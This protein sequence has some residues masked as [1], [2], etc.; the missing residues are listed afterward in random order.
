MAVSAPIQTEWLE[1][2]SDGATVKAYFARPEGTGP[3][4]GVIMIHENPGLTPHRQDVTRRLASEGYV[5]LTPNLYSRIGGEIPR[6]DDE[7]EWKRQI[8]RASVDEQVFAD[9]VNGAAYLRKRPDV[10]GDR[11]GLIGFCMGGQ[12]V[13]YAACHTDMFRCTVAFYGPVTARAETRD[14]GRDRSYLPFIPNLAGPL[15]YHV[16]DKDTACPP[17]EVEQLKQ[18]L[19]EQGKNFE[20]HVY[21]GALHAFHDDTSPRHHPE[22]ATLAWERTLPFFERYLKN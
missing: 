9:I 4:P 7:L 15:L 14:D 16:G 17:H 13:L 20:L 10:Q 19:T 6:G 5:V 22:A 21:P 12:K 3:W 2:T 18:I 1:Y 8:A 11:L